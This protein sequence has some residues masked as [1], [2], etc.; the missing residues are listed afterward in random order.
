MVPQQSESLWHRMTVGSQQLPVW[1][2]P[3]SSTTCAH[4]NPLQ[5]SALTPQAAR[6]DPAF[7]SQRHSL[8]RQLSLLQ[9]D[10]PEQC[11]PSGCRQVTSHE[12][13]QQLWLL[14]QLVPTGRQGPASPV[15][16]P[17]VVPLEP[18][19]PL[20]PVPAELPPELVSPPELVPAELAPAA[21]VPVLPA[22]E[23]AAAAVVL[24]P[25][26]DAPEP[27]PLCCAPVIT[28]W[29][30][31]AKASAP[32]AAS[33]RPARLVF[34][35]R[36]SPPRCPEEHTLE[37]C[38]RKAGTLKIPGDSH[39]GGVAREPSG[40]YEPGSVGDIEMRARRL[41]VI[42]V[43][44]G[45]WSACLQIVPGEPAPGVQTCCTPACIETLLGCNLFP[46]GA[47]DYTC[48][49]PQ[50]SSTDTDAGAAVAQYSA[51]ACTAGDEGA[52]VGCIAR[53]FPGD[54]CAVIT[55]DAGG[56]VLQSQIESA[57]PG[58]FSPGACDTAC[59]MCKEVCDQTAVE[60]NGACLDAA[61]GFYGCLGCNA[62]CN[63]VA[64]KCEL[65]CLNQ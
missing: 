4:S 62:A 9:S 46:Q 44:I 45:L 17:V 23:L 49:V 36:I 5:Q 64:A 47:P 38:D 30:Q 33:S 11:W 3:A 12:P 28:D 43:S 34:T 57:C 8:P 65:A 40:W 25:E 56:A 2:V 51:E 50:F 20:E 53:A 1:T 22:A 31:A 15:D 42:A 14:A 55:A 26:V 41:V 29:V 13:L 21:L 32:A 60:C 58:G 18:V 10:G 54:A 37:R 48:F 27:A 63:Q 35:V 19:E 39:R 6:V 59:V 16:A 52:E 24:G 7:D 61:E